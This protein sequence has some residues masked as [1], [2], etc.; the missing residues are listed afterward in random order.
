V[1]VPG[2]FFVAQV[3]SAIFGSGLEIFPTKN[4]IFSLRVWVKK[5]PGQRTVGLLFTVGQNHARVGLGQAPL[6]MGMEEW[7]LYI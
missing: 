6:V 1:T 3:G 4:Q 7:N 2:Q 5:Y